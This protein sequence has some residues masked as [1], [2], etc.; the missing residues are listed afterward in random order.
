MPSFVHLRVVPPR[1]TRIGGSVRSPFPPNRRPPLAGA[2]S[3][4]TTLVTVTVTVFVTVA[5]SV[6]LTVTVVV[7]ESLL[8]AAV[9]KTATIAEAAGASR[10]SP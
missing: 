2:G 7:S 1:R 6:A 5:T 8:Q 10:F 9:R 3:R 4:G